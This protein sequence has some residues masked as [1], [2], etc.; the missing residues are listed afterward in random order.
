MNNW[1]NTDKQLPAINE[2]IIYSG[3]LYPAEGR[4]MGNGYVELPNGG[5]DQFDEWQPKEKPTV[6]T[7]GPQP[8]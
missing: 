7:A 4:H 8:S 5:I 1:I 6:N 2:Q 3:N